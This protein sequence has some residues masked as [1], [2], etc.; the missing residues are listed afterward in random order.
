MNSNCKIHR[1]LCNICQFTGALNDYES[2]QYGACLHAG[3][4][5]DNWHIKRVRASTHPTDLPI[6]YY[7]GLTRP[8]SPA[9]REKGLWELN[10]TEFQGITG[11]TL[12]EE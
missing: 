3:D 9:P 2:L 5:T 6:F 4:G 12:P 1:P 8:D 10:S 7:K 11:N